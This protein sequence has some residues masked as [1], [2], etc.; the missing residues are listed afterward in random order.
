M[1]FS[2]THRV[3]A[4]IVAALVL[5]GCQATTPEFEA[6][7]GASGEQ[8]RAPPANAA[9]WQAAAVAAAF[10]YGRE[11][12]LGEVTLTEINHPSLAEF[13]PLYVPSEYTAL[14]VVPRSLR[15][16]VT[17][18]RDANRD[19]VREWMVGHELLFDASFRDVDGIQQFWVGLIACREGDCGYV[20]ENL[21]EY[22]G[23]FLNYEDNLLRGNPPLLA[24]RTGAASVR[25]LPNSWFSDEN[26]VCLQA[27]FSR[28]AEA[29]SYTSCGAGI[30]VDGRP[31]ILLTT[32]TGGLIASDARTIQAINAAV[33]QRLAP[34]GAG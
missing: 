13:G 21:Q 30:V 8:R 24:E 27:N 16:P 14:D 26:T 19:G 5:A 7:A 6:G 32:H 34:T 31:Y 9:E 20:S 10:R 2:R 22:T 3:L 4:L 18:W 25:F 15:Q 11:L 28:G 29:G 17:M 12:A 23:V 33:A 1:N